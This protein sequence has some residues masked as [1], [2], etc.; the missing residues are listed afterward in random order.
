MRQVSDPPSWSNSRDCQLWLQ[1][2]KAE[3]EYVF[4]EGRT[5]Q[6]AGCVLCVCPGVD[7]WSGPNTLLKYVPAIDLSEVPE[8]SR[9]D[10]LKRIRTYDS[11][12]AVIVIKYP[13]GC[14]TYGVVFPSEATIRRIVQQKTIDDHRQLARAAA[15]TPIADDAV[16]GVST[17]EEDQDLL[18]LR[19][20][21]RVWAENSCPVFRV[22]HSAASAF[23]LTDCHDVCARDVGLPYDAFMI[24]LPQPDGPISFAG[25]DGELLPG[26]FLFVMSF[27]DPSQNN[28]ERMYIRIAAAGRDSKADPA[29]YRTEVW[30]QGDE[31]MAGWFEGDG[32]LS[33]DLVTLDRRALHAAQRLLVNMCLHMGA[34]PEK[35][36]PAGGEKAKRKGHKRADANTWLVGREIRISREIRDAAKIWGT[37]QDVTKWKVRSRFLVRGHWRNQAHGPQ[38]SERRRQWIQPFWKG[39]TDGPQLDRLYAIDGESGSSVL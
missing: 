22:T 18:T 6:G 8:E 36:E 31:K 10:V 7:G 17:S 32:P 12:T 3:L 4:R 27:V 26:R 9:A 28:G 30:P 25:R 33:D 19:T 39:P 29:I 15:A 34:D 21:Y 23:I 1:Q 35:V 37:E 13:T 11:S 5:S 24:D 14:W 20:F 38:L 2:S 16:L